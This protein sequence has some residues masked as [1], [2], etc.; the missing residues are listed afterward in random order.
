M[1]L[2]TLTIKKDSTGLSVTAGTDRLFEPDGLAVQNGIHVA[3]SDIAFATRPH[4]T[5]KNRAPKYSNGSYDKAKRTV[6]YTLPITEADGS[7][8][9]NTYRGESELCASMTDA[10]ILEFFRTIAQLYINAGT[11]AFLLRGNIE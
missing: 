3:A 8:G 11:Q 4:A 9:F 1:P 2:K 7:I 10:Q 6:N 5:F